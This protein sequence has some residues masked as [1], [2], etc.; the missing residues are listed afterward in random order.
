MDEL[1]AIFSN[2]ESLYAML[3]RLLIREVDAEF[4]AALKA[5]SFP[6]DAGVA[7]LT[8]GYRM[9]SGYV[10]NPPENA[11]EDLAVDYAGAILGA[12]HAAQTEVACPYESFYTSPSRLL[13]QD[14]W[15]K[16]RNLCLLKGYVLNDR[17]LLEDHL[18]LELQY[19]GILVRE[20]LAAIRAKDEAEL[21]RNVG[22]E[23]TFLETHL[24]NWVPSFTR[25][26]RKFAKEPLYQATARIL[27]GFLPLDRE[28]LLSLSKPGEDA[29]ESK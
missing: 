17:G 15:E 29:A 20:G 24:L 13:Q 10:K 23:V 1:E 14:S 8:E 3:S 11:L 26:L 28:M 5:T 7:E 19:M 9:L 6:E 16:M 2:R 27:D 12:G 22:E 4:L 18:G 25:D 21:R